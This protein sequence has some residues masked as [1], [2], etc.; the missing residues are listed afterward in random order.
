MTPPLTTIRVGTAGW[1]I[2]REHAAGFAPPETGRVLTRYSRSFSAVEI[3]STF[4]RRHRASTFARWR[5]TVPPEFRFA[6][7]LSKSL[8][9]EAELASPRTLLDEFFADA[10]PLGD[11]LGVVLVQLAGSHALVP[12]RASAFFRA[13]RARYDGPVAFEPRHASWY[14]P[15]ATALLVAARIGRVVADPPRP[16]AAREPAGDPDLLYLRLHGSPRTYY[17]AYGP[18]RLAAI[19][20]TLRTSAAR[21]RWCIFDNTASGAAAGDALQL[22]AM[23]R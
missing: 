9:H 23:L 12:R 5:E 18:E 13:L 4:Y 1:S 3:N 21:D 8:T 10:A 15:R 19:A 16:D 20:D 22:T 2:P 11:S 17:S 14:E 6:L 7:K